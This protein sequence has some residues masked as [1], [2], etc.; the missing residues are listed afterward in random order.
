[1]SDTANLGKWYHSTWFLILSSIFCF[2]V[3]LLL[4]WTNKNTAGL[5]SSMKA[6]AIFT[7]FIAVMVIIGISGSG[8]KSPG[9]SESESTGPIGKPD[10]V[11]FH[12]EFAQLASRYRSEGNEMKKSAVQREMAAFVRK[13]IAATS[14]Q[15]WEGTLR[16]VGTEEGGQKVYIVIR[17]EI[18][19]FDIDY[20]TWNNSLSDMGDGTMIKLGTGVYKQLEQLEKGD[21]VVFSGRLLPDSKRGFKQA[22][23]LEQTTVTEPELLVIF[24]NIQKKQ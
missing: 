5:L 16:S 24:T 9:S 10:Q 12:K 8:N 15:N 22:N 20:R 11:T 14:I 7:G 21:H 17:A 23:M 19:G 18:A 4:V 6:K 2:P 1:M 13:H 3:G